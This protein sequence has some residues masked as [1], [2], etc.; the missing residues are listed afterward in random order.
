MR[1]SALQKS[2]LKTMALLFDN[3]KKVVPNAAL[4][5]MVNSARVY[6]VRK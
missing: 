6:E 1:I 4:I 5:K 3:E 2:T